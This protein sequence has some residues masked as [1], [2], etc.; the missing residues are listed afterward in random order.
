MFKRHD[1]VCI[2]ETWLR[3]DIVIKGYKEFYSHRTD[4]HRKAKKDPGGLCIFVKNEI[5][6]C[7]ERLQSA[8]DDILWLK[9]NKHK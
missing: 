4:K 3:N 1:I 9:I 5:S 2:N 8:S 7:V 6:H